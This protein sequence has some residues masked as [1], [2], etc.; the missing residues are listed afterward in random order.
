MREALSLGLLLPLL[1]LTP[2]CAQNDK[3]A[4]AATS[5]KSYDAWWKQ[6]GSAQKTGDTALAGAEQP[7]WQQVSLAQSGAG[8]TLFKQDC[9]SCHSIGRGQIVGPDLQ[10]VTHRDDPEWV[11]KFVTDPEPMLDSDAHAK[12]MLGQYLVKMPNLHLTAA[13]ISAIEAYFRQQDEAAK[14]AQK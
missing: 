13:Q 8:E 4:A 1:L 11:A 5:A 3:P 14:G 6:D 12:A 7:G 2:G 10:G 9:A